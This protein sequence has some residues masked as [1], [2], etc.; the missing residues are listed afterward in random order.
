MLRLGIIGYGAIAHHL[1]AA[2]A[3]GQLPGVAIVAIVVRRPRAEPGP[4]ARLT[5]EPDRFFAAKLDAVLECAGHA[6]VREHG[7]RALREGADLLVTSVGAF[8]D[9]ALLDRMVDAARAAK[10]RLILPSA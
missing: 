1:L 2:A 3:E 8:A 6:A 9:T 7:E 5:H 4:S 10:R